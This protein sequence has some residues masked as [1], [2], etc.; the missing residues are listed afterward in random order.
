[1]EWFRGRRKGEALCPAAVL[2]SGPSW[3]QFA[4]RRGGSRRPL[5]VCVAEVSV[6]WMN[7][8]D[9]FSVKQPCRVPLGLLMVN[10]P[11]TLFSALTPLKGSAR[12]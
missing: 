6:L 2:L 1:M 10:S 5:C 3:V 9:A 7:S 8:S 4:F 12:S 11:H